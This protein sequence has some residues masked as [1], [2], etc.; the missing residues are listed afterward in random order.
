MPEILIKYN[1]YKKRDGIRFLKK[2][3]K[4]GAHR[5]SFTFHCI[6]FFLFI[7]FYITCHPVSLLMNASVEL[8]PAASSPEIDGNPLS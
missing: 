1:S 3:R 2:K 6:L 5:I 8:V 7:W 4:V